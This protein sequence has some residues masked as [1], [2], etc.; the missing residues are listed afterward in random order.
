MFVA[1]ITRRVDVTRRPAIALQLLVKLRMDFAQPGAAA[2]DDECRM[3]SGVRANPTAVAVSTPRPG[4][5]VSRRLTS[6]S[7]CQA[8]SYWSSAEMSADSTTIWRTPQLTAAHA[9]GMEGLVIVRL[10]LRP[11]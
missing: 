3:E 9:A 7:A 10:I 5:A 2:G 4:I 6:L 8:A 1:D 11:I